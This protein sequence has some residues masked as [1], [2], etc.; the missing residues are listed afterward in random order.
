MEDPGGGLAGEECAADVE[1]DDLAEAV[2]V[3]VERWAEI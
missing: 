1:V 2:D 3:V